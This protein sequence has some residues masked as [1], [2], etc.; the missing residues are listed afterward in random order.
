MDA[1]RK[2][3]RELHAA[4]QAEAE[5]HGMS[6]EFVRKGQRKHA[7]AV[8]TFGGQCRSS[9]LSGT[10]SGTDRAIKM[11]LANVRQIARD[12]GALK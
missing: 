4:V 6:V 8:F 2:Y 1:L 12:L 11:K 9:P 5:A 7:T 3:L 10:P